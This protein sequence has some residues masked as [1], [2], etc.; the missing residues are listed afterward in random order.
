MPTSISTGLSTT[1]KLSKHISIA[2]MHSSLDTTDNCT[3]SSLSKRGSKHTTDTAI[4]LI[5]NSSITNS[6]TTATSSRS[7]GNR[8]QKGTFQTALSIQF[9]NYPG[10]RSSPDAVRAANVAFAHFTLTDSI[11]FRIGECI[12]FRRYTHAVQQCG[13][14]YKP[15]GR[16]MVSGKLLDTTFESYHHEEAGKLFEEPDFYSISVYGDGATIKTTPLINLLA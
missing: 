1:P 10:S 6:V 4:D 2:K 14:D 15:P 7:T 9:H 12:L 8:K 16:N 3:L 5:I 11:S 13:A